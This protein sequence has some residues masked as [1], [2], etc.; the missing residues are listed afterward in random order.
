M[1][2]PLQRCYVRLRG[3]T[4][5]VPVAGYHARPRIWG[6]G[7]VYKPDP[8]DPKTKTWQK[9]P[10]FEAKLYGK[11]GDGSGVNP[12]GLWPSPE[13]LREIEEEEREWSPGLAEM[14]HRIETQERDSQRKQQ[15]KERL[16]AANLAKMPQ[17]VANWRREKRELKQKQR[18]EKV[19]KERLMALA[20]EKFGINIDPRSPKFLEM[21]K[22]LEKQEKKKLKALKKQIKEEAETGKPSTA[23]TN[24]PTAGLS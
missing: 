2:A 5:S 7:G 8:N 22:D 24:A 9:G 3:L 10:R 11:H 23:T 13:R 15:E 17:M 19:R 6:L 1:A 20:H 14:L 18:D 4:L 12:E 21:V 16:I